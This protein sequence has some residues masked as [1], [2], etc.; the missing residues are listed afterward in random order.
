MVLSRT[1]LNPR[2]LKIVRSQ[3]KLNS[4]ILRISESE[5]D[6]MRKKVLIKLGKSKRGAEKRQLASLLYYI[7]VIKTRAKK[8]IFYSF[9]ESMIY[10]DAT[11]PKQEKDRGYVLSK[12]RSK[13]DDHFASKIGETP[14]K[15][16]MEEIIKNK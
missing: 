5:L 13:T 1:E 12:L 7:D 6:D 14:Y 16:C 10:K 4:E 11:S 3:L 9:N 2:E 8:E 15:I